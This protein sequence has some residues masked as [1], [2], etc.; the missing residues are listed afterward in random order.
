MRWLLFEGVSDRHER[1]N[2]HVS[3]EWRREGE[4][5]YDSDAISLLWSGALL[6]VV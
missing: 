4:D 5:R 3:N 1:I 6:R 2:E